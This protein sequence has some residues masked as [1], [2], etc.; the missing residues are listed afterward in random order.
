M[1]PDLVEQDAGCSKLD[2][3]SWDCFSSQKK[4]LHNTFSPI[5]NRIFNPIKHSWPFGLNECLCKAVA[6]QKK[7]DFHA[8]T[9]SKRERKQLWSSLLGFTCFSPTLHWRKKMWNF[10][11]FF[12][13]ALINT[14]LHRMKRYSIIPS[15]NVRVLNS[16]CCSPCLC[17]TVT[18]GAAEC[19]PLLDETRPQHKSE[20][21][22]SMPKFRENKS[23]GKF[24]QLMVFS[25]IMKQ[26]RIAMNYPLDNTCWCFH[27]LRLL[28]HRL[29]HTSISWHENVEKKHPTIIK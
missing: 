12:C 11:M 2:K 10:P 24:G 25:S 5:Q 15:G 6:Y 4:C 19:G 16:G 14:L 23:V 20:L 7:E 17:S 28:H 18:R 22:K 26:C 8:E 13:N 3:V 9:W 21:E 27:L 1:L 29:L